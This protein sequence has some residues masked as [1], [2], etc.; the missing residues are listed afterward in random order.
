MTKD[1]AGFLSAE[2]IEMKWPPPVAK[3]DFQWK[4]GYINPITK[5]STQNLPCLQ[6]MQE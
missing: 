6:D 2:D 1:F 5:P 4:E 3:Q